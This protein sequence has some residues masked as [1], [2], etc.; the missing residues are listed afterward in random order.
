MP[1]SFGVLGRVG[2]ILCLGVSRHAS[3]N[4]SP[5]FLVLVILSK[6]VFCLRLIKFSYVLHSVPVA[7]SH[8]LC[9]RTQSC[10]SCASLAT[11][12]SSAR[13]RSHTIP[14]VRAVYSTLS[15]HV[16]TISHWD[17][18]PCCAINSADR[19]EAGQVQQLAARCWSQSLR[20]DHPW[21]TSR[22]RQDNYGSKPKRWL[23]RCADQSLGPRWCPRL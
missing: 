7:F 12:S 20:G 8:I 16:L 23:L 11:F 15:N 17:L 6:L 10:L 19:E 18:G 3:A 5:P 13:Q 9:A 22:S 4:F 21:S 14:L 1:Q 2:T